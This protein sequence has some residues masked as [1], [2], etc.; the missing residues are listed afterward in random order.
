MRDEHH[1]IFLLVR[2]ARPGDRKV[3]GWVGGWVR[4][5]GRTRF[6]EGEEGAEVEAGEGDCI[7]SDPKAS[8][9]ARWSACFPPLP[10]C[11]GLLR[12]GLTRLSLFV[13]GCAAG[14]GGRWDACRVCVAYV[15]SSSLLYWKGALPRR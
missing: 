15:S 4:W 1:H 8:G 7:S 5:G 12:L 3:G 14:G 2:A 13:C 6:L 9:A 10:I 11:L